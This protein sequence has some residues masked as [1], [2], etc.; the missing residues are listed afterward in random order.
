MEKASRNFVFF[1][2]FVFF[3]NLYISGNSLNGNTTDKGGRRRKRKR[4][5]KDK[6]R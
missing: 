3:I 6:R 5:E 2:V 4:E 1:I